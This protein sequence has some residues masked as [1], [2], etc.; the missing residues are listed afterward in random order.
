MTVA[1]SRR[2]ASLGTSLPLLRKELIEQGLAGRTFLLRAGFGLLLFL[3]FAAVFLP[4]VIFTRV[5]PTTLLGIGAFALQVV[6][7]VLAGGVFLFLPPLVAG[8]LPAERER[9]SLEL[10]WITRLR[11]VEILLEKYLSRVLLMLTLLLVALPLFAFAYAFGGITTSQVGLASLA[12]LL[13]CLQVGAIAMMFSARCTTVTRALIGT[14]VCAALLYLGGALAIAYW[15]SPASPFGSFFLLPIAGYFRSVK[16]GMPFTTVL[17]QWIPAA[18]SIVVFLILAHRH[19]IRGSLSSRKAMRPERLRDPVRPRIYRKR[20][21]ARRIRGLPVDDPVSWREVGRRTL[22]RPERASDNLVRLTMAVLVASF[23]FSAL[24]HA[25]LWVVATVTVV[26]AGAGAASVERRNQ[27]FDL[28]LTTPLSGRDIVRQK[29]RGFRRLITL[30]LPLFCVVVVVESFFYFIFGNFGPFGSANPLRVVGNLLI[31]L[32]TV[33][34]LLPMFGYLSLWIGLRMRE[35]RHPQITALITIFLWSLL[36]IV[37]TIPA[38]AL[39]GPS[40]EWPRFVPL[41]S[42]AYAMYASTMAML[43]PGGFGMGKVLLGLFFHGNLILVFRALCMHRP[44]HR[45]GRVE[46]TGRRP[47]APAQGYVQSSSR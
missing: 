31:S 23:L 19:L 46:D 35:G 21:W 39:V 22:G 8:V 5:G 4:F 43:F 37:L 13:T 27:T 29:A 14:Y 47:R 11:P 16:L 44:D 10:L 25:A 9:G 7:S 32:A 40:A 42:P 12:L 1:V 34:I 2:L 30:F 18:A 6:V 20:R 3:V 38:V 26:L 15:Y 45:L 17:A 24:V 36:P 28:L 41:A 33:V